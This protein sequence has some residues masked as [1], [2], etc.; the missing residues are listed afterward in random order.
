MKLR[1]FNLSLL[2]LAG[3]M[4]LSFA[5]FVVADEKNSTA[6]NVFLD[7]DLDDLTDAEEK[8]YGTDPKNKDTDGDGY[9]D[10]A[11][12]RAGYDPKKPAP[13]D[14]IS[15]VANNQA[16]LGQSA[17]QNEENLTEKVSQKITEL[18]S[19]TGEDDQNVSVE[20]I[21]A[22][23]D[24]AMN[25]TV[26]AE[27]LPEIDEKNIKIKKQNY[28]GSSEKIEEEKKEDFIDYITSVFY[29]FSSNSPQPITSSNDISS[30]IMEFVSD[31]LGAIE[32]RDSSSLSEISQSGEKIFEQLS[33]VEVPEDLVELHI[34]ALRYAKYSQSL[35]KS[36]DPNPDDPI[37]DIANF[38]KIRAFIGSLSSF[39]EESF[40]KFS[41]YGVTYDDTVKEKL[42]SLGVDPP[43][44][45]EDKF[46]ELLDELSSSTETSA[47]E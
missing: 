5:F 22:L 16:V 19:K 27:D 42:K 24:E 11:E 6:N 32:K 45:D 47:S 21:Q 46:T 26:T 10:G 38:S 15:T 29:I 1:N 34:K 37:K 7:S 36:I 9:S 3:L 8:T 17:S 33:D 35:E 30:V 12:V 44:I 13:G 39:S 2:I 23:V 4:F 25:S 20:E 43:D 14:K 41:E 31:I 28:T 40:S 18:T